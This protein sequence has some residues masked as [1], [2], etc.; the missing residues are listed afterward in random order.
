MK[1]SRNARLL[2]NH[3]AI[4]AGYKCPHCYVALQAGDVTAWVPMRKLGQYVIE[5]S[6]LHWDCYCA[7]EGKAD[8][9]QQKLPGSPTKDA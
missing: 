3:E 7:A 9:K 1:F 6:L 8:G 5:A 4:L 2:P